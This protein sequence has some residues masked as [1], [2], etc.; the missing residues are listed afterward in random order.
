LIGLP[1]VIL[2]LEVM[3]TAFGIGIGIGIAIAIGGGHS[4]IDNACSY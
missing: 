4:A 3:S 2:G 1:C